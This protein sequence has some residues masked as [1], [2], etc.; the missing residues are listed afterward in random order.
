MDAVLKFLQNASS[1]SIFSAS[2]ARSEVNDSIVVRRAARSH[3]R[4]R[5]RRRERRRRKRG[6]CTIGG[7]AQSVDPVVWPVIRMRGCRC[8]DAQIGHFFPAL[9]MLSMFG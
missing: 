4:R 6:P 5:R 8:A 2:P 1:A 7:T 9:S 3:I